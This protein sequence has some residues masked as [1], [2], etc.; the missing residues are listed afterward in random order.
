MMPSQSQ[1]TVVSHIA[2]TPIHT[3]CKQPCIRGRCSPLTGQVMPGR[4]GYNTCHFILLLA[5][6]TLFP[7]IVGGLCVCAYVHTIPIASPLAI[8]SITPHRAQRLKNCGSGHKQAVAPLLDNAWPQY[9]RTLAHWQRIH[10]HNSAAIASIH[11]FASIAGG[12][13]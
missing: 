7:P 9:I 2:S 5:F 3:Q 11:S 13:I 4:R 6:V 1:R 8:L 12:Y 10:S